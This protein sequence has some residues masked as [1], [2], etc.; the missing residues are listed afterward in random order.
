MM[1]VPVTA[2]LPACLA[3]TLS[4]TAFAQ[5]APAPTPTPAAQPPAAPAPQATPAAATPAPDATVS[6]QGT[7]KPAE[8][9]PFRPIEGPIIV[10]LPSVEVPPAGTLTVLFTHRFRTPVQDSDWFH[11]LVSFDL[12]ADIGIGL[13]YAPLPNLDVSFYRNSSLD[14][15]PWEFAAKY[16]IVSK[17]PVGLSLRVGGDVRS[18]DGLTDRWSF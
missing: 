3:L 15:D 9:K 12:G 11:D 2:I 6:T 1:K 10:S 18:E 4:S 17:G 16:R 7:E 8:A 13:A 14:L 5:D